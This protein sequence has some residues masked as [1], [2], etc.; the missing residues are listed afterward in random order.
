MLK[1]LI[2]TLP[3]LLIGCGTAVKPITSSN[4]EVVASTHDVR[5]FNNSSWFISKGQRFEV[6]NMEYGERVVFLI[7]ENIIANFETGVVLDE[8]NCST[9]KHVSRDFIGIFVHTPKALSF[10]LD[11]RTSTPFPFCF[12]KAN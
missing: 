11:I 10:P 8:K 3:L 1:L 7:K 4:L 6:V 12:T 9:D 2:T 5:L